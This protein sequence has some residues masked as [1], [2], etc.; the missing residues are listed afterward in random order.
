MQPLCCLSP[1]SPLGGLGPYLGGL[2]GNPLLGSPLLG[3]GMYGNPYGY[4]DPFYDFDDY[5]PMQIP[6]Q[7]LYNGGWND[8]SL[9]TLLGG[10][11]GGRS[12]YRP[13]RCRCRHRYLSL[14]LSFGRYCRICE[15]ECY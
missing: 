7:L 14:S 15:G 11:G 4:E 8:G 3:G 1:Y 9:Y 6:G 13:R 10:Y 12:F 5:H 2:G